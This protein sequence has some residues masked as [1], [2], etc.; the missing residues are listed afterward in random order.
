[1]AVGNIFDNQMLMDSMGTLQQ[2]NKIDSKGDFYKLLG[3]ILS[4]QIQ[5]G[6]NTNEYRE[7]SNR[8]IN[9]Q[10]DTSRKRM[11]EDLSSRGMGGSGAA[12][13]ALAGVE[14]ERGS[15][16][17]SSDLNYSKMEQDY[18]QN[19][20]Q[21]LINFNFQGVN[22]QNQTFQNILGAR[23]LE[24]QRYM[25]DK[26]LQ[27]KKDNQPSDFASLLGSLIGGGAQVLSSGFMSNWG[28]G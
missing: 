11:Q 6:I 10:F 4:D 19:A 17:A 18:L 3:N 23:G 14:G 25:F 9:K 12:L 7:F 22:A 21:Q 16:L 5:N 2:A 15:A 27:F 13:A 1:M 24:Q 20:L 26:E 28:K 8:T